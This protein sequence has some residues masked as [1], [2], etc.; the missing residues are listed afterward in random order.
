MKQR[1]NSG[2]K[3]HNFFT[4]VSVFLPSYL[5]K[6]LKPLFELL[7]CWCDR[8]APGQGATN[9]LSP[10]S[11]SSSSD[12]FRIFRPCKYQDFFQFYF[13]P[14]FC[15]LFA[16]FLPT[17]CHLFANFLPTFCQLFAIFLPTF[18]NFWTIFGQLFHNFL[19]TFCQPF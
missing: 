14:T 8:V 4:C 19:P 12:R 1:R 13:L 11:S 5:T 7:P 15:Q 16:N 18:D 6:A 2:E 9:L 17:L 3:R 10:S